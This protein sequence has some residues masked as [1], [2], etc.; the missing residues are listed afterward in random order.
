MVRRLWKIVMPDGVDVQA[1]DALTVSGKGTYVV[2]LSLHPTDYSIATEVLCLHIGGVLF[3]DS[4]TFTNL[5]TNLTT[6]ATNATIWRLNK[7][8]M[9]APWSNYDWAIAFQP[10]TYSDTTKPGDGHLLNWS[11]VRG[12]IHI[13]RPYSTNDPTMPLLMAFFKDPD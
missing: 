7:E 9:P 11:G 10:V 12:E 2:L 5:K 3:T 4:V 13:T 1:G 6:P 8:T